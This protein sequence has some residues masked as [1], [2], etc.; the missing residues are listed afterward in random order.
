MFFINGV[1]VMVVIDGGLVGLH[2]RY[3]GQAMG[4]HGIVPSTFSCGWGEQPVGS[5]HVEATYLDLFALKV[6]EAVLSLL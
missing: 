4:S 6:R 1:L 2:Y 3:P 5:S